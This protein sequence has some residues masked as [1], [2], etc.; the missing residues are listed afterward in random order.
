MAHWMSRL[1]GVTPRELV[2]GGRNDVLI[3]PM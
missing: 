2:R 1:L 3:Q